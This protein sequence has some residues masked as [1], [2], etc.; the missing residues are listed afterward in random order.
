MTNNEKH[1]MAAELLRVSANAFAAYA[2][3]LLL[4][5]QPWIKSRFG[6]TAFADW[7]DHYSQ[8]IHELS[9]AMAESE[10]GLFSSRVRWIRAAFKARE[11]PEELLH[12]S[13]LCLEEILEQELPEEYRQEPKL[14]IA[15]GMAALI[16]AET[17]GGEL[18]SADP[19]G[20]LAMQ[21]MA[22]V[23]EGNSTRAIELVM[24]A[25]RN[26]LSLESAY[27]VLMT[28]QREIG[29]MWHQAE[30]NI[31]EEHMVSSTTR[32]AMAVLA[33]HAGKK[34]SNGLTVVAAAV[35]GNSHEIGL[36]MISDFFEFA[37]WRAICLGADL[38]PAEI[39]QAVRYFDPALLLLSVALGTQLPAARR[40]IAAVREAGSEC[41]I[42]LG[43]SA[44]SG[45]PDIWRKLGAD[46]FADSPS[47]ALS[48]AAELVG[49][50]D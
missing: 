23:L 37:G 6:E 48:R 9:V 19:A 12:Q 7:K 17:A 3:N 11:L 44:L 31:A 14:F 2:S 21:Y 18:D 43:G 41:K 25:R 24:D 15:A 4:E 8:T 49:R 22:E 35:A 46:A 42:M 20:K 29:Q 28:A 33:Y 36:R 13:L 34:A 40:T 27:Q 38:P 5:R 10:P 32:R 45:A 47:E 16:E 1:L 30:V 50:T 39:A 26:G